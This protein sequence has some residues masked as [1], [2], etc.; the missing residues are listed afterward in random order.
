MKIDRDLV[1]KVARLAALELSEGEETELSGQL[2]RIVEHFEALRAVPENL[3]ADGAVAPA[4]PLRADAAEDGSPGGL[5][6]SNAPE[7]AHGHFVVPRV[8]SRD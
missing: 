3:L 4:T 7:F 6:E 2:T 8:V 5:V 1:A